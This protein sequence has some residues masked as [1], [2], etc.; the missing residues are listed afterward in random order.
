MDWGGW[1]WCKHTVVYGM[2]GQRGPVCST[3]NLTQYSVMI[4]T[5]KY[6]LLSLQ[7]KMFL[8]HQLHQSVLVESKGPQGLNDSMP[9]RLL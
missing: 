5:G 3:G 4:Y 9:K 6:T 1:D 2:T 8:G 7:E